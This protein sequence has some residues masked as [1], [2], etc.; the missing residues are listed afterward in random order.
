MAARKD[1]KGR[2][3]RKG[4]CQRS[5]GR[6]VYTYT[7]PLGKRRYIYSKNLLKL[8]EKEERLI[9]DQMDGLDVY[10]AGSATLNMVFDRYLSTKSEL[11]STTRSNYIWTWNYFIRDTFGKKKIGDVK[12]SDVLQFYTYLIK[13]KGIEVNSL[14]NVN[15]VLFPTF[16]LAVRDDI[17]RKNPAEGAFREVKRRFGGHRKLRRAMTVEQQKAFIRYIG[18]NPFFDNWYPLFTVLLGT[19][20]RVGEVIGLRWSAFD[21]EN[22]VFF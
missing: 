14:E 18:E 2:A 11:K 20:C 15:T 21:F 3:L 4:E 1:G 8:R 16:K 6:Y 5:D 12:Y 13:E 22:D 10:V 7:D 9:R 19:G 17:I